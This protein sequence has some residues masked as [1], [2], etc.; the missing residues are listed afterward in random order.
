MRDRRR[1][2]RLSFELT[3]LPPNVMI[4]LDRSGSMDGS[5]QN[6]NKTRW[7]V[8]KDA[9]FQLVDAFDS[10]IRFGLVTYSACVLLQGCSAG[11]IEVA[12]I[13]KAGTFIKNFLGPKGLGYLCNSGNPETSTGNTLQ[14]LVGEKSLQDPVRSNAVLLI[15][16]GNENSECQKT[17]DG[18]KAAAALLAQAI[19]VKTYAVGFSDGVLG[20]LGAVAQ[21][22]GTDVPYNATDPASLIAALNAIAANV[23]SCDFILDGVPPD[24]DIHVFFDDDPAGIPEDPVDG[25]SYDPDTNTL[26]FHGAACDQLKSGAVVDIDVVFG[27]AAPIPG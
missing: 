17:T 19:P 14:A 23:A 9:I 27:C 26:R 4:V 2:R 1:L 8:A 22:G 15:T 7:E 5:V 6:S 21:A 13:D 18:A 25:W 16:D 10:D 20:S 24:P 11:E 12:I 3:Q